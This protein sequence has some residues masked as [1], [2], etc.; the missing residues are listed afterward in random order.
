MLG[1]ALVALFGCG[2]SSAHPASQRS[3]LAQSG[4]GEDGLGTYASAADGSACQ[5][6]NGVAGHE[7][8]GACI[9]LSSDTSHCGSCSARCSARAAC[10]GGACVDPAL[11]PPPID[12]TSELAT[13][14]AISCEGAG[15]QARARCGDACCDVQSDPAHCGSCAVRCPTGAVC[16]AGQCQDVV[17]ELDGLRWEFPCDNNSYG[18]HVCGCAARINRTMKVPGA[19][20]GLYNVRL[21]F[22]GVVESNVYPNASPAGGRDEAARFFVT[23]STPTNVT[24]V[25]AL[26]V[27]QPAQKCFLNAERS[28]YLTGIDYTVTIT[29]QA[30]SLL[31]LSADSVDRRQLVNRD[32]KNHPIIPAGV[33]PAPNAFDGQFIQMDVVS[34]V[35]RH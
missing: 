27:D 15:G 2:C 6:S 11:S 32:D 22:R 13:T 35:A 19:G 10:S 9:D 4:G 21:R 1:L 7:C 29:V 17:G 16:S 8:A 31:T 3:E 28:V 12:A 30:G 18:S 20:A 34:V 33:P 25:Y 23:G 24:N 26:A 14:S 5:L